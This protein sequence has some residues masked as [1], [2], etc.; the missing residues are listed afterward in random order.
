MT[1]EKKNEK[2][3]SNVVKCN[4]KLIICKYQIAGFLF[5]WHFIIACLISGS[6]LSFTYDIPFYFYYFS[7]TDHK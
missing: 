2:E 4:T 1:T 7:L 6:S 3:K 5:I